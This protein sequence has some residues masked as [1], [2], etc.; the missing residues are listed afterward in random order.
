MLEKDDGVSEVIGTLLILA[1]T[2]A[3]FAT[4]FTFVNTMPRATSYVQV[5][6]YPEYS[7][8]SNYFYLNLT[9]VS[10]NPIKASG[11]I[12]AISVNGKVYSSSNQNQYWI[13]PAENYIYPGNGPSSTIMFK[14][15][16]SGNA[17]SGKFYAYV[18]YRPTTQII[19]QMSFYIP[20]S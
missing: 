3:L 9:F 13:I 11:I 8:N 1:I 6:I 18:D 7:E 19:W 20:P 2:V 10:G 16:N 12:C 4:V 15:P 17:F 14:A 5:T